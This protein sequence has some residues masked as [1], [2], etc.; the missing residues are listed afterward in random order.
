MR[1]WGE[2]IGWARVCKKL[3]ETRQQRTSSAFPSS[4]LPQD[5]TGA[6]DGV[7]GVRV[8]RAY[9]RARLHSC[10]FSCRELL[11][12]GTR[13]GECFKINLVSCPLQQATRNAVE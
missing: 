9:L 10:C 7:D 4:K 13:T 11:V 1:S 8:S 3:E 12:C 5:A 2:V 6:L